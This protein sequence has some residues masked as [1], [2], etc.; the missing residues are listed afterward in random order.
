VARHRAALTRRLP[1]H[2]KTDHFKVRLVH[3]NDFDQAVRP[4]ALSL[5][6]PEHAKGDFTRTLQV[7]CMVKP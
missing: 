2:S 3:V 4:P 7:G 5:S 6:V 1:A